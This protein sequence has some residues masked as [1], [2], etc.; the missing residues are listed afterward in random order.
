MARPPARS[1]RPKPEWRIE[2][3]FEADGVRGVLHR[4][5]GTERRCPRADPRRRLER[6]R[7]AAGAHGRAR[8]RQPGTWCCAT[9]CRFASAR[10]KGPPFPAGAA[11]DREGIARAVDAAARA[12]ARTRLRRRPFLRRPADRHGRRRARRHW[13]TALLLLS[14]P[15]HPPRQAGPDAHRVLSRS[16][17]P[18]RC[19]CTAPRIRSPRSKSCARPSR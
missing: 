13:P 8:S 19:S 11:R 4:P 17:A 2:E 14:Y 16:C 12:G 5:A 7:A 1:P 10:P 3:R 9:I 15:L 6:Q 18:R